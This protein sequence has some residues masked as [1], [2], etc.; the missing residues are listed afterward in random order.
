MNTN[1]ISDSSNIVTEYKS[2]S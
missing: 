1:Q 2:V